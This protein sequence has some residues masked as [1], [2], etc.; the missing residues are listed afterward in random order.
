MVQDKRKRWPAVVIGL[1]IVFATVLYGLR[2]FYREP[3]VVEVATQIASG[4]FDGDADYL[5]T[6]I[7]NEELRELGW[8]RSEARTF[9]K[10]VI[11]PK[12]V[13]FKNQGELSRQTYGN[14]AKASI[15]YKVRTP[16]GHEFEITEHAFLTD[17]G[18]RTTVGSLLQRGWLFEY[19][20]ENPGAKE[21]SWPVRAVRRGIVRDYPLLLKHKF[22]CFFNADKD[23]VHKTLDKAHADAKAWLA[24]NPEKPE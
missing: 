23:M 20:N 22:I 1:S 4:L 18:A 6:R 16:K 17:D 11:L 21:D 2:W 19:Q 10:E 9:L 15:R 5:A 12:F 8:D 7:L 24:A 14:G 13:G 3:P